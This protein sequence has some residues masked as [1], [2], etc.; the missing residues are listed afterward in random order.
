[1]QNKYL[2]FSSGSGSEDPA[3]W[4]REEAALFSA[5][6]FK[7]GRPISSFEL[8]LY[9]EGGD[10]VVLKIKNNHHTEILSSIGNAI[11]GSNSGVVIIADADNNR[12]INNHIYDCTIL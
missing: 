3:N 12:F 9:F 2:L 1:M 7:G 6:S 10:I 5:A 8:E 4:S 11:W